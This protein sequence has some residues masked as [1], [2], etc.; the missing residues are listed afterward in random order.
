MVHG[1]HQPAHHYYERYWSLPVLAHEVSNHQTLSFSTSCRFIP[2][3]F[4]C[5]RVIRGKKF[6]CIYH[7]HDTASLQPKKQGGRN[8]E[9]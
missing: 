3:H 1:L 8:A 4:V 9:C 6:S 7:A 2:A 5:I